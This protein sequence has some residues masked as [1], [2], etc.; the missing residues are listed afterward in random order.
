MASSRHHPQA[1]ILL[2]VL[3]APGLCTPV[4]AV[5]FAAGTGEPNDPYQIATA[6]QLDGVGA[7][8]TSWDKHFQLVADIDL[9]GYSET[10]F[11][12]LGY[13]R[14]DKDSLPFTGVFDGAG[15][16][17]SNF[18]W[19]SLDGND[20]GL[21]GYIAEAR[22]EV[23]NLTLVD[24]R[25]HV[26]K[27]D[28]VA[29]LVGYLR[30]GTLT[31]CSTRGCEV[32]VQAGANVGSLVGRA[33]D[34]KLTVCVT[35][36]DIVQ[37]GQGSA[38]GALAGDV[39]Q[40]TLER[41]RA[42][43]ATVW[44]VDGLWVGGLVGH[45]AG[46]IV[47]GCQALASVAGGTDLGGLVGG[48]GGNLTDCSAGGSVM[49]N[50]NVGG[51]I[52]SSLSG[53]GRGPGRGGGVPVVYTITRCFATAA[54]TGGDS[55]GGLIGSNRAAVSNCYATSSV[56]G[57]RGIG[58]VGGLVGYS[59][60]TIT[61]CYA[62]GKVSSGKG[63]V[64]YCYDQA[65]VVACFWDVET[66][67]QATSNG[68]L[69]KTSAQMYAASTFLIWAGGDNEG[70]WTIDDGN[71]YPRLSWEDRPGEVI[72]L[73]PLAGAG[74]PDDPYLVGTAEELSQVGAMVGAMGKCFRLTADVDLAGYSGAAFHPI[75]DAVYP[76]TGVFDGSGHAIVNF[77]Y[78][79][80]GINGV[81]LFGV[82]SDP[83]AR[84]LNLRLVDPNV[85]AEGGEYTGAL[86]G[87]LV[88]GTLTDC[89]VERGFVSGGDD[90]GGLAGGGDG[91]LTGCSASGT[92]A[93]GLFVG[94]LIGS[95]G[96]D[97]VNCHAD[98]LVSGG[99]GVGGLAGVNRGTI[100]AS[101]AGGSVS[102]LSLIAGRAVYSGE[103]FGG[104]VG[105]NY[106]AVVD[107]YATGQVAGG[108]HTGGLVGNNAY[109]AAIRNC[110]CIGPVAGGTSTGGLVGTNTGMV[111]ACFWDTG[112][113]RQAGSA[114]GLGK[115]TSEMKT[116]DTFLAWGAC[117]HAGV[118]TQAEGTYPRLSW[119][120]TT[121][122]AM[123]A[124]ELSEWLEGTGTLDNPYRIYTAEELNLIGLFP[125]DW[126]K[127]FLLVADIDL[128]ALQGTPFNPIGS[129]Q[130]PFTGVFDGGGH[131][132]SGLRLV[133]TKDTSSPSGDSA[134][135]AYSGIEG[136]N[137]GF[138]GRVEGSA[139]LVRDIGL[140]APVVEAEPGGYVGTLVGSLR[141]GT[142]TGCYCEGGAVTG[143]SEVGGLVGDNSHGQ[144]RDCHATACVVTGDSAVGG[145]VG[146]HSG[147]ISHCAADG[148]V[149][150]RKSVG[151]LVGTGGLLG[152]VR[153]SHATAD[154]NGVEAV[155]GLIGSSGDA[156]L[157]VNCS[158]SGSVR[159]SLDV[160]GLAGNNV[161]SVISDCYATAS[162]T[163]I[164]PS[165]DP[166]R[167]F[168]YN[169]IKVP[170]GIA[171]GGLV[172][173]NG[174]PDHA[175]EEG[176]I[177]RCYCAGRVSGHAMVRGMVGCQYPDSVAVASFW[178]VEATGQALSAAGEGKSTAEMQ[179]PDTFRA[180]G[181][182]FVGPGD[183]PHDVWALPAEGGYPTL[184]GQ[185]PAVAGL[186]AFAGGS[187]S[188]DDPYLISTAEQLNGIGYNPR[189]M[190]AH[191]L[192]VND[193]D[194][195]GA[196][197]SC[198]G[199]EL[200]PFAGVFDGGGHTI[201]HLGPV[202][203]QPVHVGLL[204]Y[205]SGP[206]A[207]IRNLGLLDPNIHSP[208]ADT[209]GSLVGRLGQA[210]VIDCFV[211]GGHV[212]GQE[213]VG[214]LVGRTDLGATVA[215]CWSGTGVVGTNAIGG[216]VG[217]NEAGSIA[218]CCARSVVT[219][220]WG[221][222]GL[223]GW[224][225]A[226]ITDCYAEGS[227]EG[228]E[229]V[230]GLVGFNSAGGRIASSYS[231]A[232]VTGQANTGGLVGFKTGG[233]FSCSFWDTQ[234]SGQPTSAAG[235]EQRTAAM[236]TAATFVDVGWDFADVWMICEGRDYPRLRWE[237]VECE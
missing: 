34:A 10:N 18:E 176:T 100:T 88:A 199:C 56:A 183:G 174:S 7:D 136:V 104:L 143:G 93:G 149:S 85:R 200:F 179:N 158:S 116:P 23:R 92:V 191:F 13:W 111:F 119:E 105:E 87:H 78:A 187:G 98:C 103:D 209:V 203:G 107:S 9:S 227:T 117:G 123:E 231:T 1:M 229:E 161:N 210:A 43:N 139:A 135:A 54:V 42:E 131:A 163:W 181:W 110:Y 30:G 132:V 145:L 226:S 236:Q 31:A 118:W 228:Q 73:A 36:D 142:V 165:A 25:V 51:L 91:T 155:G 72:R 184:A 211:G 15:H 157:I 3:A 186:P 38:V 21:F 16:S 57:G 102:G 32:V 28:N 201:S 61:N 195:T 156:S 50:E 75:G 234:T 69:G 8:P 162:V 81:G 35:T 223:A 235:S 232:R 217:Y 154:V 177:S 24:A 27:G 171:T 140:I 62:A 26:R 2:A 55:V 237:G 222:G 48:C 182:D 97:I 39:Q 168:Y 37:V 160:G 170:E 95:S 173:R 113:T 128:S 109:G 134:E 129:G 17:L 121:G 49:G 12:A 82:V 202:A 47:T 192:L 185:L 212:A 76:F 60:H 41:C 127:H 188:P 58:G 63:L 150:G 52:G 180:A 5:D 45:F 215:R 213:Y 80:Q 207:T 99:R 46:G 194:L 153:D 122:G 79:A 198:I 115:T 125:C 167:S 197:F 106:G 70:V 83:N 65:S 151:G 178:D 146:S 138:F 208:S 169:T 89:H 205:V 96:G 71:D 172:G 20:V 159:G 124:V 216:L 133:G 59:S 77:S 206:D 68:G 108:V 220:Q 219:G 214:G 11:H 44:S 33:Q 190:D 166:F 94:G 14:S 84:I 189:L 225:D 204:G 114:G 40:G 152:T 6:E 90:V 64:G 19:T 67:G 233:T 144:I 224:N 86:V 137:I 148:R 130:V 218:G 22:A 101:Y 230:G 141:L 53:G 4:R 74:T 29:C 147:V 175:W 196:E 126:D 164:N 66:S 221:I 120:G 193:I 112:T